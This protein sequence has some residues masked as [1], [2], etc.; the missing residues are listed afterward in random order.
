VT[1]KL[2]GVPAELEPGTAKLTLVT[3]T[4][5]WNAAPVGGTS[6]Q[7]VVKADQGRVKDLLPVVGTETFA[8]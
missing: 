1:Q 8:Q 3:P 6:K 7:S 2:N 5:G 4:L